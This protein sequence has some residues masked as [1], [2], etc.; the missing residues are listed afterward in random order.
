[1]TDPDR[2]VVPQDNQ[3]PAIVAELDLVAPLL[4]QLN[5]DRDHF[6]ATLITALRDNPDL[7]KCSADSFVGAVYKTA[8]L[9]LRPGDELGWVW[10]IPRRVKVRGTRSEKRWEVV[11]ELGYKGMIELARRAGVDITTGAVYPGDPFDVV[12][13]DSPKLT[14]RHGPRYGDGEAHTWY[15]VARLPD[16]RTKFRVLTK[17]QIEARRKLS[18]SQSG[19]TPSGFWG[20]HGYDRMARKTCVRALDAD[21]PRGLIPALVENSGDPDVARVSDL[22]GVF[23]DDVVNVDDDPESSP[24]SQS[25]VD[26]IETVRDEVAGLDDALVLNLEEWRVAAGLDGDAVWRAWIGRHCQGATSLSDLDEQ[27]ARALLAATRDRATNAEES[28]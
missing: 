16:G 6:R 9:G 23:R 8:R 10:M 11:W 26:V 3:A 2:T 13:G 15:A 21:I 1:M 14:H 28:P 5:I 18:P 24:A 4:E 19:D 27:Q 22:A 17:A 25:D 12:E 20:P 7:R